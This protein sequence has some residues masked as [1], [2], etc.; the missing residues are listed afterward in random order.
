VL[1]ATGVTLFLVGGKNS[2]SDSA[3]LQL[4]PM[5][6]VGGAGLSALGRF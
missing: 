1:A 6:T 2:S 4:A 5:A 3:T